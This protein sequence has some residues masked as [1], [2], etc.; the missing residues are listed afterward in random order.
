MAGGCR[1]RHCSLCIIRRRRSVT[2]CLI[3]ANER[4]LNNGPCFITLHPPQRRGRNYYCNILHR[5]CRHIRQI[6]D[7]CAN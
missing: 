1:G 5:K 2:R 4:L 6:P 3:S 7:V